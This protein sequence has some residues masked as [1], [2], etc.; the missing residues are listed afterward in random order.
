MKLVLV[1][2]LAAIPI[3]CYA[4]DDS[5]NCLAMDDVIAQLINSSVPVDDFQGVIKSYARLP[6][7]E[8]A[9]AKVK[10]CYLDQSEETLDSYQVM[11]D[12][13]YNSEDC[14]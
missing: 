12:A 3:C 10:E 13:I 1:F 5:S 4:G 2:V 7:D 14:S 11:M 6:Y 9:V 8:N